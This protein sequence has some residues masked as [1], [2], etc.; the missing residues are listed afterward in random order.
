MGLRYKTADGSLIPNEGEVTIQHLEADGEAYDFTIQN[1]KV[2]C[3]RISVRYLVTR[4]CVVI[5]H[6]RGVLILYPTGKRI[7]FVSKD[8]VFFVP[9]NVLPPDSKDIFGNTVNPSSGFSRHG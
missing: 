7:D 6:K 5:S 2:H 8:G 4:D 9:L 3:P 1:A